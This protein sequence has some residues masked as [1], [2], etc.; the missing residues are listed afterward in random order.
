M[1]WLQE[2]W[3]KI[4]SS[5]VSS[6]LTLLAL[7]RNSVLWLVNEGRD[8][9]WSQPIGRPQRLDAGMTNLGFFNVMMLMIW[10]IIDALKQVFFNVSRCK[11]NQELFPALVVKDQELIFPFIRAECNIRGTAFSFKSHHKIFIKTFSIN[12]QKFVNKICRHLF[13]LIWKWPRIT[14]CLRHLPR[15]Y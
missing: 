10:F 7:Y 8:V 2:S 5:N 13:E 4:P 3:E 12:F 6:Q 11:C 9:T 15:S 14:R 1:R